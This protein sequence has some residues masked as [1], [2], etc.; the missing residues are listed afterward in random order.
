MDIGMRPGNDRSTRICLGHE[1]DHALAAGDAATACAGT[2]VKWQVNFLLIGS[3][4]RILK[5]ETLWLAL[6]WRSPQHP[7]RGLAKYRT[8]DLGGWTVIPEV[9]H[10][11]RPTSLGAALL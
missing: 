7:L 11:L 10:G 2:H 8:K 4:E 9:A 6:A 1:V 3:V 5:T